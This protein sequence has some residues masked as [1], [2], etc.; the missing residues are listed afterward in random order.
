MPRYKLR[1]LLI[2]LA[3]GP[4]MLAAA[5]FAPRLTFA[6]LILLAQWDEHSRHRISFEAVERL[7]AALPNCSIV[8]SWR[9]PQP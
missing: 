9:L 5:Y 7:K 3:V 4:P 1:K 2:L 6:F 8:G